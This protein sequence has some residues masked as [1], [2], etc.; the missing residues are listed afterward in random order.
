[1]ILSSI[2]NIVKF[3]LGFMLAVALLIGGGVATALYYMNRV[4]AP[5]PKP[6]FANDNPKL[7]AK[8]PPN[9]AKAKSKPL[10]AAQASATP[11]TDSPKALEPG[12]YRARVVWSQGLSLRSGPDTSAEHVGS[13]IYNQRIVVLKESADKNWQKIRWEGST[14]EGWIKAG[15][16]ERIKKQ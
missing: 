2:A 9:Y 3:L 11:S 16:T 8:H 15:N 4:S 5:P 10:P 7:K 13:L 6:T 14:Q 12:A 1:M